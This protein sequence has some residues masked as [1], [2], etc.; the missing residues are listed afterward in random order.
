MQFRSRW[1]YLSE[2]GI[3][4]WFIFYIFFLL[5]RLLSCWHAYSFMPLLP[6]YI[7]LHS[8]IVSSLDTCVLF[9]KAILSNTQLLCLAFLLEFSTSKIF[10]LYEVDL[11]S[12]RTVKTSSMVETHRV[13]YTPSTTLN[14]LQHHQIHWDSAKCSVTWKLMEVDGLWVTPF[15]FHLAWNGF[16]FDGTIIIIAFI[17][18]DKLQ[19]WNIGNRGE[20][21]RMEQNHTHTHA[22]GKKKEKNTHTKN[23][24][25]HTHTRKNNSRDAKKSD[26]FSN[27]SLREKCKI[28]RVSHITQIIDSSGQTLQI[29]IIKMKIPWT[30]LCLVFCC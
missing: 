2:D 8:H 24:K 27:F 6:A 13:V 28:V 19:A 4:S 29:I 21:K 30:D 9:T 23:N 20:K 18:N 26:K 14:H 7:E 16:D 3:F 12:Q 1:R 10:L 15:H 22:R 17:R 25:K 5:C 11:C